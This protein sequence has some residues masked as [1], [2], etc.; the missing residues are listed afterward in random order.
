MEVWERCGDTNENSNAPLVDA[1]P[2][3]S[4]L[5]HPVKQLKLN[6]Y[7]GTICICLQDSFQAFNQKNL[8]Q[9]FSDI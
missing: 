6:S 3:L 9:K 7:A 2:S 5:I 8:E 1:L 4:A